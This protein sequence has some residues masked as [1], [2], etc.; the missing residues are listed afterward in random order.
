MGAGEALLAALLAAGAGGLRVVAAEVGGASSAKIW[1]FAV[2]VVL[3][4]ELKFFVGLVA[5]CFLGLQ[6]SLEFLGDGHFVLNV[7][8]TTARYE[9]VE[10]SDVEFAVILNLL[11]EEGVVEV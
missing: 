6:L 4:L 2:D 11:L 8:R 5:L 9:L 1:S 3:V 10:A 7:A